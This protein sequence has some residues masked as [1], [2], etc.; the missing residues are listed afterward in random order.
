MRVSEMHLISVERPA[1]IKSSHQWSPLETFLK[2]F[3]VPAAFL[4]SVCVKC[5]LTGWPWIRIN[6]MLLATNGWHEQELW[7]DHWW[8]TDH[9]PEKYRNSTLYVPRMGYC[10]DT[11]DNQYCC[12]KGWGNNKNWTSSWVLKSAW[13]KCLS[14]IP[15]SHT[16]L[17]S[18]S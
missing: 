13:L 10:Q 17:A 9:W 16:F 5:D 12:K 4:F 11:V 15:H 6:I 1:L 7:R 14:N 8:L 3:Q 2:Y 18:D